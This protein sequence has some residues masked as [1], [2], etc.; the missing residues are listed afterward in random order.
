[1]DI[2]KL[3]NKFGLPVAIVGLL[4]LGLVIGIRISRLDLQRSYSI[5]QKWNKLNAVLSIVGTEY[6]DDIDYKKVEVQTIEQVLK[7]LDPHS[8]YIPAEDMKE[9][10]E[11]L[12]GNFDGIGVTFNMFYD[13]VVVI[14]TIP[15]GPSERVGVLA[16]DRIITVDERSIAGQKVPQDSVV[17]MLRG[18]SGS[19]V[20][21][22]IERVGET[23][24]VPITITRG[25]IPSKSVDVSYMITPTTGYVKLSKFSRTTHDEFKAASEKLLNA[26]MDYL[27]FDLRGNSG[28]YLDQAFEIA[29]EFLESGLLVVYVQGKARPRQNLY[30]NRRGILKNIKVAVLI[31]EGSASASEIVAG[32][33]QDNDRGLVYGR[34]SFG[35]GL[36]QEPIGF[37]D[38]SGLRLTVAR[39]YTPTGRCIQRPYS[40]GGDDYYGELQRR[41][42]HGELV[43]ADSVRQND[44]LKYITPKDRVVYGGGGIM[45]DVFVPWDTTGVNSYF[46]SVSRKNLIYKFA[47]NISDKNR[48]QLQKMKTLPN[49]QKYLRRQNLQHRF[50]TYA[51]QNGVTGTDAEVRYCAALLNAQIQAYIGRSTPL[52]DEGFYPFLEPVDST[53]QAALKQK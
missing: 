15:G 42:D 33:I 36:V 8:V 16:G 29:N 44:T 22:G 12:E 25:K 21:V 34:R 31:D 24:L 50:V 26:G 9:V 13:T 6:V 43:V 19:K 39:Y 5:L 27:I 51:A 7:T 30:A 45:P 17:K 38:G 10:N 32:A 11:P 47:L 2:K 3:R 35:K 46:R 40:K 28:G 18:K 23:K 14:N 1:M 49:L 20:T 41:Y 4:L 53:L 52:D 37:S 48:V